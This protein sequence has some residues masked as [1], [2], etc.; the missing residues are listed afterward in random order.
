[1]PRGL[2]QEEILL[3]VR[4][5]VIVRRQR[6]LLTQG[7][8]CRRPEM[9]PEALRQRNPL[10]IVLGL[11]ASLWQVVLPSTRRVDHF[12]SR[13]MRGVKVGLVSGHTSPELFPLPYDDFDI[14][15]D[16]LVDEQ[17]VHVAVSV[18]EGVVERCESFERRSG[19]E[20]GA[21]VSV[22][23]I[24]GSAGSAHQMSSPDTIP[25][26]A[27]PERVSVR[28]HNIHCT[29]KRVR[30][31]RTKVERREEDDIALPRSTGPLQ[32]TSR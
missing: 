27:W 15:G 16:M 24:D 19:P 2:T 18:E 3:L 30:E 1:M 21:S 20:N 25:S 4:L 17:G 31:R 11:D 10:W 5:P 12:L 28:A 8:R 23:K 6:P 26:F 22:G 7:M 9:E 32:Q 14:L 29:A 13:E